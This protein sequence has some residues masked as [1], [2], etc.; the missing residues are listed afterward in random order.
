[1]PELNDYPASHTYFSQRLRLHY[2]DWG[3]PDAPPLILMH[4][5]R[6]HCRSWD[7]VALALRDR[8]HVIAPDLRG[9]GDSQWVIGSGYAM[10]DYVYDLAHLVRQQGPRASHAARALARRPH[11]PRV[12]RHL[13]PNTWRA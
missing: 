11:L 13:P 2:V 4:G 5:G 1:M 10:I 6:D 3:N 7:W 9:H 8:Y 12:R